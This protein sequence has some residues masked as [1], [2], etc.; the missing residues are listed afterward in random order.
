MECVI[1]LNISYVLKKII[2]K[3]VDDINSWKD[4]RSS[5]EFNLFKLLNR[6]LKDRRLCEHQCRGCLDY[7]LV[8]TIFSQFIS[9]IEAINKKNKQLLDFL[10][11]LFFLEDC[12]HPV[13]LAIELIS[14][15]KYVGKKLDDIYLNNYQYYVSEIMQAY[16]AL[17]LAYC[18]QRV[19]ELDGVILSNH[20]LNEEQ[21]I[22]YQEVEIGDCYKKF[23]IDQNFVSKCMNEDNLMRQIDNIKKNSK[24]IFLSSPYIIED[25]IKMNRVFLK[26]YFEILSEITNNKLI[27]NQNQNLSFVTENIN[28]TVDRVMLWLNTTRAA[29]NLKL[30]KARI[31]HYTYPVFNRGTGTVQGLNKDIKLFFSELDTNFTPD[32]SREEIH[33]SPSMVLNSLFWMNLISFTPSFT[34]D[35]IKNGY[36]Q[37]ENDQDCMNKIGQI[38]DLL[39]IMNF[40]TEPMKDVAKIKSSYQDTEHL[41]HSWKADY[42]IT[43]DGNL[44]DRGEYVYSLLGLKT[45]FL[46][47]NEFK[48]MMTDCYKQ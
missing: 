34:I 40:K 31:N 43:D 14:N 39:D 19:I 15:T 1:K 8:Q 18:R 13:D 44:K 26:S 28:S 10:V 36:I 2:E 11:N 25:G 23:Y 22:S 38:C 6:N 33:K 27:V 21:S 42:F 16:S 3:L 12:N 7:Y 47:I 35:D 9:D 4:L 17:V 20:N 24:F 29:E 5:E 45:Q 46:K 30:Y 48:K 32:I 37:F 41:K